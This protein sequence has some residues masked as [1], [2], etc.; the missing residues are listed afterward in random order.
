SL[1]LWVPGV[2]L[3]YLF[4]SRRTLYLQSLGLVPK[5]LLCVYLAA[6]LRVV[7]DR[8]RD[9]TAQTVSMA[10]VG[11]LLSL[12]FVATDYVAYQQSFYFEGASF[13]YL[14]GLLLS[15]VAFRGDSRR[16]LAV[17]LLFVL[18]L[19]G[20]KMSNVYWPVLAIPSLL[21]ACGVHRRLNAGLFTVACVALVTL[22]TVLAILIVRQPSFYTRHNAYHSLF[23]GVLTFSND[24]EQRLEEIGL[25]DAQGC[26]GEP[27][28]VGVGPECYAKYESRMS[29]VNTVRVALAEPATVVRL[30]AYGLEMMQ[31]IHLDYLGKLTASDPSYEGKVYRPPLDLWSTLKTRFFPRERWLLLTLAFYAAIFAWVARKGHAARDVGLV[32]LLATVATP[33]DILVAVLGDG[34]QEIVKHLFLSNVLFDLATITFVGLV[35]VGAVALV[36]SL[37]RRLPLRLAHVSRAGG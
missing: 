37:I 27:A 4:L 13:V 26:V 15:F 31:Q 21:Y 11:V 35:R 5:V 1:L 30:T 12:M 17:G 14:I 10:V 18:L 7:R 28:F 32:G 16:R 24:P 20:T 8:V 34:K 33:I 3:N 25:K 2:L 9:Q 22:A 29:F 19:A 6:A 36:R 23:Y